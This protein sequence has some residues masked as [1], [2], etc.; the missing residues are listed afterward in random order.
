MDMLTIEVTTCLVVT[1]LLTATPAVADAARELVRCELEVEHLYPAPNN[2]SFENWP[3][4]QANL[5]KRAE[6]TEIACGQLVIASRQN[7]LLLSRPS[8][9]KI[10]DEL[11]HGP[12]GNLYRDTD[13]NRICLDNE[14]DVRTQERLS[15]MLSVRQ[16]VAPL[17]WSV[18]RRATAPGSSG[19]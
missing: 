4:R 13:W 8:C 10:A 1:L 2:K 17:A 19:S 12:S 15:A 16:L 3:E 18:N 5:R 14:W 7:V 11:M 6:N 9:M